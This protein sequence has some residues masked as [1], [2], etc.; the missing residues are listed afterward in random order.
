MT[1][2]RLLIVLLCA[3][4][5]SQCPP[6][7]RASACADELPPGIAKWEDD[8]AA[9]EE[10]DRRET[11]PDDAILFLGS[12]S[13]RLWDTIARDMAP[14]PVIQR[15]YGGAKLIDLIHYADRLLARHQP[16]AIVIFVAND[17]V[18]PDSD[19]TPDEAARRFAELLGI[20]R[21]RF[22]T[23]P[24]FWVE[25]TLTPLRADAWNLVRAATT[26][27]RR[28]ID[29]DP[30]CHFI[31]TADE[32]RTAN[33]QPRPELFNDDRLHQNEAGYAIWSRIIK[34]RLAEVLPPLN[35]EGAAQP[36]S[37]DN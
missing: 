33:L 28:V 6:G 34:A 24:V 31:G 1:F 11:D 12:S 5:V 26:E 21:K 19:V 32:Y 4:A 17:I 8:V 15:G 30:N 10:R 37:I 36:Q 18:K 20:V 29:G 16:R 27:I 14:Y 7:L 2:R 13:I 23:T 9:L 25:V 35:P 3:L 22:P